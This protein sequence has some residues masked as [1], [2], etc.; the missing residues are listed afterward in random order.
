M[1][2]RAMLAAL[3]AMA[4]TAFIMF[5]PQTQVVDIDNEQRVV[6]ADLLLDRNGIAYISNEQEPFTGRAQSKYENGQPRLEGTFKDG[7][8]EGL[9]RSWD[10][11]GELMAEICFSNGEKVS[12]DYCL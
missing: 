5:R 7:K 10:E 2:V 4:F 3:I 1:N 9:H 8:P 12:M 11:N 6:D